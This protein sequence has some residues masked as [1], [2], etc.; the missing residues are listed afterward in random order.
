MGMRFVETKEIE[1]LVLEKRFCDKP[2]DILK[3]LLFT[4]MELDEARNAGKKSESEG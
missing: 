4:F 3:K 2:E 1:K